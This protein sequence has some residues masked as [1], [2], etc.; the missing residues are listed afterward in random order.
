MVDLP[1][2]LSKGDFQA[3]SEEGAE[4]EEKVLICVNTLC[5]VILDRV[6]S[7]VGPCLTGEGNRVNAHMCEFSQG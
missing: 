4:T 6:E 2:D 1:L 3:V 5:P 7:D